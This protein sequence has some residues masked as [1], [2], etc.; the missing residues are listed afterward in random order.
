MVSW[1]DV[2]NTTSATSASGERPKEV[3]ATVSAP[4]SA[5][6][7]RVSIASRVRPECDRPIATSPGPS[8]AALVSAVW[9]SERYQT[10]TR[11]RSSRNAISRPAVPLLP[12][13]KISTRPAVAIAAATR[14]T[15]ATSSPDAVA[16][17][18]LVSA[19]VITSSTPSR[20]S[21]GAMSPLMSVSQRACSARPVSVAMATRR[22]A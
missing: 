15:A 1:T 4:W 18:A 2:V 9:V 11:M 17:I 20:G 14:S 19:A 12:S 10:G 7:A 5:A 8:S 22:L 13:P 21:S 3:T 16:W 6:S